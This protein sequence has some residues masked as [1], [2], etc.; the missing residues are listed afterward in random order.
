MVE[1]DWLWGTPWA[2]PEPRALPLLL[3]GDGRGTPT[4]QLLL[5]M[6]WIFWG[7]QGQL[8]WP[9]VGTP[10]CC[11]GLST[12]SPAPLVPR[13]APAAQAGSALA[14]PCTHYGQSKRTIASV[15]FSPG[16]GGSLLQQEQK[17]SCHVNISADSSLPL[18]SSSPGLCVKS[19]PSPCAARSCR[20]AFLWLSKALH[21]ER[22]RGT[23]GTAEPRADSGWL[24]RHRGLQR[25]CF[26]PTEWFLGKVSVSARWVMLARCQQPHFSPSVLC[27]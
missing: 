4:P 6:G 17:E 20:R 9:L 12:P 11:P 26:S 14:L 2:S 8:P 22:A 5:R 19:A 21:S 7:V 23:E 13:G 15:T 24:P 18:F 3:G 16:N 27:G 10:W 1:P 25:S